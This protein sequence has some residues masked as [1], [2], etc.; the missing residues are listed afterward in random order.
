MGTGVG[1]DAVA[2]GVERH[3]SIGFPQQYAAYDR[4]AVLN[5][6]RLAVA[7]KAGIQAR[8]QASSGA[9]AS[10]NERRL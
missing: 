7:G 5:A 9:M 1:F 4:H 8:A 10:F 6:C 2:L 3:G